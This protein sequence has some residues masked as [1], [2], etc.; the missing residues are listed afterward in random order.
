MEQGRDHARPPQFGRPYDRMGPTGR[1]GHVHGRPAPRN[2]KGGRNDG[3]GDGYP[4]P[5]DCSIHPDQKHHGFLPSLLC[6]VCKRIGHV[7]T[8]CNMLAMAIYLDK[9]I[10]QSLLEEDKCKIESSWLSMWKEKLGQPQ[11]SPA[12]VMNVY[13][14]DLDISLD[15]LNP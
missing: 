10:K 14:T 7:A 8:N 5:W 12:Q 4:S 6:D 13:C 11:Q 1:S 2:W 3:R 15:H 9:Y